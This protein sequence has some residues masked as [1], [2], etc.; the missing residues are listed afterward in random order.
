M[1]SSTDRMSLLTNLLAS[2]TEENKAK[3]MSLFAELLTENAK[4]SQKLTRRKSQKKKIGD[5]E[6]QLEEANSAVARHQK[7][8]ED[9][10][11]AYQ[12]KQRTMRDEIDMLKV[13]VA[14]KTAAAEAQKALTDAKAK[15]LDESEGAVNDLRAQLAEARS[16]TLAAH[17]QLDAARK[18]NAAR[19][20]ASALREQN[21]RDQL[22]EKEGSF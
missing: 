21:L 19:N 22:A 12:A 2:P 7:Y 4:M 11:D 15:A 6:R 20:D 5:L 17:E 8:A 13:D 1:A 3:T 18:F 9:L 16:D 14:G 10:I